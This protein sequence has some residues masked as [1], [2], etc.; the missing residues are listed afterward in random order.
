MS[1]KED[2]RADCEPT[3]APTPVGTLYIQ[4]ATPP[5]ASNT[6][7][8]GARNAV[9]EWIH[10]N[11]DEL[12]SIGNIVYADEDIVIVLATDDWPVVRD[13]TDAAPTE[14]YEVIQP[15]HNAVASDHGIDTM[16]SDMMIISRDSVSADIDINREE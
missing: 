14:V 3:D 7:V 9:A 15:A 1:A 10:E 2:Y 4:R 16:N 11:A 8:M 13:Q 12:V 6:V 5:K